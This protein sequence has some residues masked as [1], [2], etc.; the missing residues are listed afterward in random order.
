MSLAVLLFSM[1]KN[2]ETFGGVKEALLCVEYKDDIGYAS[3][4]GD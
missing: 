3:I 2:A 1:H 4:D